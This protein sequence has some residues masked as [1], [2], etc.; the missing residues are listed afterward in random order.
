MCGVCSKIP[1]YALKT[2]I[3]CQSVIS[4]QIPYSSF[5]NIRKLIDPESPDFML[6]LHQGMELDYNMQT[7]CEKD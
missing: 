6:S 4:L 7:P 5:A 2:L 3:Q 1:V